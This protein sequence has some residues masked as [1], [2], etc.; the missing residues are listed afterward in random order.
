MLNTV[1]VTQREPA[2]IQKEDNFEVLERSAITNTRTI[3]GVYNIQRKDNFEPSEIYGSLVG[4]EYVFPDLTFETVDGDITVP[5]AHIEN[6]ED[7]QPTATVTIL[8]QKTNS[9]EGQTVETHKA[10]GITEHTTVDEWDNER[11]SVSLLLDNPFEE[12]LTYL[13]PTYKGVMVQF[14]SG[15]QKPRYYGSFERHSKTT[16]LKTNPHVCREPPVESD[17]IS[18]TVATDKGEYSNVVNVRRGT[19]DISKFA[20]QLENGNEVYVSTIYDVSGSLYT[21]CV[22]TERDHQFSHYTE[23]SV[24]G[25]K[26]IIGVYEKENKLY[27]VSHPHTASVHATPS[28]STFDLNDIVDMIIKQ[29]DGKII[30]SIPSYCING[31]PDIPSTVEKQEPWQTEME[32]EE[33]KKVLKQRLNGYIQV[34]D[35]PDSKFQSIVDEYPS[36]EVILRKINDKESLYKYE[37]ILPYRLLPK[38]LYALT[39]A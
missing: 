8:E 27:A 2:V 26:R 16:Q 15:E 23:T 10:Y 9:D 4:E 34:S 29:P 7:L 3:E 14:N 1:T 12:G 25:L 37:K 36:V 18:F 32:K 35:D 17:S 33:L 11:V 31:S 13:T 30:D 24:S 19:E 38:E 39:E 22:K 20:L 28:V 21:L 5:R 6:I